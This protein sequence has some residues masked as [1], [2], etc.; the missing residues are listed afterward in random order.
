MSF[1]VIGNESR[2]IAFAASFHGE[3]CMFG[4]VI[5]AACLAV[6]VCGFLVWNRQ[7][8]AAFWGSSFRGDVAPD[9]DP[10]YGLHILNAVADEI[11]PDELERFRNA[12]RA[13]FA[14]RE[15]NHLDTRFFWLDDFE[16]GRLYAK[17]LFVAL[18]I[19]PAQLV[20]VFGFAPGAEGS[21]I[22]FW[23]DLGA[24]PLKI[25]TTGRYNKEP[26]QR[27]AMI[28]G[29]DLD[30]RLEPT[31]LAGV[32]QGTTLLFSVECRLAVAG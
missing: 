19:A 5:G 10:D 20:E 11:P 12:D 9:E 16:H 8:R 2:R 14:V 28:L 18:G 30:I 23:D 3:S 7:M 29:K 1:R 26:F 4:Y 15:M 32:K 25:G 13:C 31:P 22:G 17:A 27:L 21:G 6:F 24:I